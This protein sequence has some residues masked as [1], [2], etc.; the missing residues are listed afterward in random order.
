MILTFSFL[1]G[2]GV[3]VFEDGTH[4]EGEFKSAGIFCG[5]GTLTFRSGD[6]LEGNM[7][8]A[9]NEGVKVIATLHMNKTSGTAQSNS[10]PA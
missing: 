2:H 4:Y 9:W 6:R 3:M 8:G 5:K 7:N 1:K 10:K